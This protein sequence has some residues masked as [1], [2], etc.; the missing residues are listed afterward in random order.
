MPGAVIAVGVLIAFGAFDTA[1]DAWARGPH[2]VT[3]ST[4]IL[5]QA[6]NAETVR[7]GLEYRYRDDY[8]LRTG[9]DFTADELG[10]SAGLGLVLRLGERQGTFDYAWTDGRHLGA[11]HRFSLGF[12]L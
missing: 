8:A 2:R 3:G 4:V 1:V 5:H 6:D 10:L 7:G 11:V 12:A 9:Y